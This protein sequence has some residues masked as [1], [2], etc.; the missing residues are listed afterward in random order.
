VAL[1]E[2]T[3]RRRGHRHD[4]VTAQAPHQPLAEEATYFSPLQAKQMYV[5]RSK[6]LIF[7]DRGLEQGI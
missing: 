5:V 6:Y 7:T 4:T 2:E 1:H 3:E